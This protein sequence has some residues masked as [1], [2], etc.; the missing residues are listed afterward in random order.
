MP[1]T[2]VL[3]E[4]S[5]KSATKRKFMSGV[6][7]H[8]TANQE[9]TR[10]LLLEY[11]Q[12]LMAPKGNGVVLFV[13]SVV[14][15]KGAAKIQSEMDHVEGVSDANGG[16][17]L[18]GGHDYCTQEMVNLLLCGQASSN[19]FDGHQLLEGA[20][21]DDPKAVVLKGVSAQANVGFLSLFEAYEYL[22]VGS[23]LKSPRFNVWVVCSESHYSVLF[24]EP[25]L[26]QDARLA[27]REHLELFY[28]D[29]LANQDEVIRLSVHA[30]AFDEKPASS[31]DDLVPPLNLVIRTKWPRAS[32]DW[33]DTEP[34]L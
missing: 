34:L 8:T 12:E 27:E 19:V 21:E 3:N 4:R 14:L 26:L 30:L 13:A 25:E 5:D 1:C 24:A 18:I 2:I 11:I 9:E 17:K 22:V 15:S 31:P 28:Y 6:V 10:A 16:G 32:V 29:G 20:S 7:L 23:H 33:N